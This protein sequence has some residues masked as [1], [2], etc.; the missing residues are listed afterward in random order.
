MSEKNTNIGPTVES[1]KFSKYS[2]IRLSVV[3]FEVN[4]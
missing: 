4:L 3:H 2:Y 1:D